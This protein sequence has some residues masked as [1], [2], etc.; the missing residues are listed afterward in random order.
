MIIVSLIG[1]LSAA[2]VLVT[3]GGILVIAVYIGT[4]LLGFFISWQFGACYSWIAQKGDITGHLAPLF[5]M[6]VI[7]ENVYPKQFYSIQIFIEENVCPKRFC[8][9]KIERLSETD[10]AP[11]GR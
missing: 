2:A 11:E 5:L 6:C 7:E 10:V 4:C 8:S 3:F 1:C 9:I